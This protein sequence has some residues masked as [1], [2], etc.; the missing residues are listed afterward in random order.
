MPGAYSPSPLSQIA[1]LGSVLGGLYNPNPNGTT[2]AANI[3]TA[4]SSLG[5]D[6]SGFVNK[7]G[8]GLGSILGI[9]SPFGTL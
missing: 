9:Q 8:T 1:G 2:P 5:S 4:L 6:V 3:G 7:L